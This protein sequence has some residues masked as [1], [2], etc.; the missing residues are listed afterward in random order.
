[1]KKKIDKDNRSFQE[2][3]FSDIPEMSDEQLTQLQPSHFRIGYYGK[4]CLEKQPKSTVK[5]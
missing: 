1:M 3:D 2:I 4:V 5:G